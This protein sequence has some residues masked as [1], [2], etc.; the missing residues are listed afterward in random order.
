MCVCFVYVYL[1]ICV[2]SDV[3]SYLEK[4]AVTTVEDSFMLYLQ[5]FDGPLDFTYCLFLGL[6]DIMIRSMVRNET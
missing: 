1:C 5:K 4:I 2:S 3:R 6:Y